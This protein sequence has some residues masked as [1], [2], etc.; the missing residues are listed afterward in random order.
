MINKENIIKT[1][2]KV[3]KKKRVPKNDVGYGSKKATLDEIGMT[4]S[5]FDLLDG[6]F[7]GNPVEEFNEILEDMDLHG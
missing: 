3:I 4:T 5:D 1:K 6:M 7:G 2:T